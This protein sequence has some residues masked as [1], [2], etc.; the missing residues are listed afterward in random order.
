MTGYVE[1]VLRQQRAVQQADAAELLRRL[2]EADI[3]AAKLEDITEIDEKSQTSE[4]MGEWWDEMQTYDTGD[5]MGEDRDDIKSG[6]ESTNFPVREAAAPPQLPEALAAAPEGDSDD[7]SPAAALLR[8]LRD[9]DAAGQSAAEAAEAWQRD[10]TA[11]AAAA[12]LD[13]R[14]QRSLL[15]AAPAAQS[16]PAAGPREMR[17]GGEADAAALSRL[18]ERDARRYD[19]CFEL[20]L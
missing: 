18:Y 2:M 13:R 17:R 9:W 15:P 16:L 8:K 19:S 7:E 5:I 4:H 11:E 12:A 1:R 6:P 3:S 20:P 10:G 14:L